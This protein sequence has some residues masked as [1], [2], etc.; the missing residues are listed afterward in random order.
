MKVSNKHLFPRTILFVVLLILSFSMLS[1]KNNNADFIVSDLSVVDVPTDNGSGL[2][3]SWKPLSKD[4]RIIEYR[5][6]RG[7]SPDSLFFT[8][9]IEVNV[10]TGFAGDYVRFS[11]KSWTRYVDLDDIVNTPGKLKKEVQQPEDSPLFK[12]PPRD[13][14]FLN[15]HRSDYQFLT[16]IPYKNLYLGSDPYQEEGDETIYAK[17]KLRKTKIIL[18]KLIAGKKYYYTVVAVNEARKFFPMAKPVFGIP[19]IGT[20]EVTEDFY[21][22]NVTDTDDMNFEWSRPIV[23]NNVYGLKIYALADADKAQFEKY[24]A[25][26]V[27]E[28]NNMIAEMSAEAKGID[29]EAIELEKVENPLINIFHH[30]I[31]YV[32]TPMNFTTLSKKAILDSI[33]SDSLDGYNFIFSL[34]FQG[35]FEAYSE[36][37]A[38]VRELTKSQLPIL[39][40]FNVKDEENDSGDKNLVSFAKPIV[41]LTQ[42]TFSNAAETKVMVNYEYTL[43]DKYKLKNINFDVYM[44]GEKF[45]TINEFYPDKSIEVK[46]PKGVTEVEELSFNIR[47]KTTVTEMPEDYEIT[48][49]LRY[50]KVVQAFRADKVAVNGEVIEDYKLSIYRQNHLDSVFKNSKDLLSTQRT[51][52]DFIDYPK[53]MYKIIQGFV[54]EEQALLFSSSITIY[55]EKVDK[56]FSTSIFKEQAIKDE[57][58]TDSPFLTELFKSDSHKDIS[59]KLVWA[60]FNF[61]RTFS[62]RIFKT[63]GKAGFAFSDTYSDNNGNSFFKPISNWF[64]KDKLAMLIATFLFGFIVFIMINKARRGDDLYIRP[65]SG[66]QEI[67]NAIGRATEMGKPILFVPGLSGIQDVA[68]LAGL[69]ILGRVAKKAAEY[70]TKILVPVRDFIVLPV[71]QETVKEAYYEAGKPDAYDPNSAFFLTTSQFAFVA[72][73]NGVMIREET[74]TNFYMGMFWAEALIMTE[75]G[76]MTGAI[77]IAGTDAITQIP[78]FITTC[79]YTLIGEELY[80]ASAYLSNEPLMLGTLKAQ[81]YSK[82]IILGFIVLGS[83]LST[84][85]LTFL[86]NLLPEK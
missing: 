72:G 5:I 56:S 41:Y 20:P 74:A 3:V 82:M 47:L 63:D 69:S 54:P 55:D 67:D 84:A 78:F 70:D 31:T 18:K 75:T 39:P 61:K 49:T 71:A 14:N 52:S 58:Y 29:Y 68:T 22:V 66:I 24:Q 77:Q 59:K 10:K 4:K 26:L 57:N 8:G 23:T 38:V 13:V 65:I 60:R 16:G 11:D 28:Q 30:P 85:H 43:P 83:I 33:K 73:V 12:T 15:D 45:A 50:D 40:E 1:A 37:P 81:D 7:V 80:A 76:N 46:L 19:E 27:E 42:S 25:Y 35:P 36:N 2:E 34:I 48:Q 62:Y 9:N 44:N 6:Y 86:I 64:Y 51:H 53:N 32:E 17:V 79:D 21:A